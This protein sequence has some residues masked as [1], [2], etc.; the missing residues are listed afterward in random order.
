MIT[1]NINNVKKTPPI[2]RGGLPY[3]GYALEFQRNPIG[4]LQRG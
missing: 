3:L 2:M 4:L 1:T